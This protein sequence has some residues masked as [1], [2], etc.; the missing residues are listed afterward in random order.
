MAPR[1]EF[2]ISTWGQRCRQHCPLN[3]TPALGLHI[4]FPPPA[5]QQVYGLHYFKGL[6][7]KTCSLWPMVTEYKLGPGALPLLTSALCSRSQ[8]EMTPETLPPIICPSSWTQPDIPAPGTQPVP[9]LPRLP[10]PFSFLAWCPQALPCACFLTTHLLP[11]EGIT[12]VE[13]PG[14]DQMQGGEAQAT[15]DSRPHADR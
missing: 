12:M 15:E 9:T 11:E 1:P 4:I 13:L 7:P 5:L 6:R 14:Q 3:P 10:D 2:H 8:M